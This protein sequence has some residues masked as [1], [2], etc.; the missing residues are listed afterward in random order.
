MKDELMAAL[1]ERAP[2]NRQ[3]IEQVAEEMLPGRAFLDFKKWLETYETYLI[4]L[5]N[6]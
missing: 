2:V 5:I 3:I 6:G 4:R 1:R